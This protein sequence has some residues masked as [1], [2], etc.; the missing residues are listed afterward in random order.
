MRRLLLAAVS[1]AALLAAE[2]AHAQQAVFCTNCSTL[3]QELAGYARQLL[4]L[5]QEITTAEQAVANTLALPSTVYRDMTGE[6]TQIEAIANQAN[7]LNGNTGAM[8]GKLASA[9]GYPAGSL[10]QWQ[11]QLIVES[12]TIS[13]A[14]GAAAKILQQQQTSLK[15][16]AAT[17]ASLQSQALGTGGRQATLQTLAGLEATIGQ[18]IQSQQGTLTAALQAMLTYQT[19]QADRE[20]YVRRLTTAQEQAGIQATC[21]AAAATGFPTVPACQSVATGTALTQ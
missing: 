12:N 2:P 6:V 5:Q 14:M 10:A 18:Q 13:Q 16:N 9:T 15:T 21:G 4:Q 20:A 3:T 8:L 7:M 17:L 1:V 11:N 19:A